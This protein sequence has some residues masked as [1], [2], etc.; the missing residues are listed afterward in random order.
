MR[1]EGR[2]YSVD[3]DDDRFD[4]YRIVIYFRSSVLSLVEAFF[5]V[6]TAGY[7]NRF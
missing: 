6:D 3:D 1:G 2:F 4:F 7:V 5:C